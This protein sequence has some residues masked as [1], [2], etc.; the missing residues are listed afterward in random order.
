MTMTRKELMIKHL[1]E[2]KM[3]S[4]CNY[5]KWTETL[6][7][8]KS[9]KRTIDI[10]FIEDEKPIRKCNFWMPH[11]HYIEGNGFTPVNMIEIEWIE[12]EFDDLL[13]AD[14]EKVGLVM[15]RGESIRIYGHKRIVESI[16]K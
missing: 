9:H 3:A 14:L 2:N 8:I 10:K 16:Q 5:T 1:E 4:L 6:S 7:I 13:C 11:R 12:T 15:D